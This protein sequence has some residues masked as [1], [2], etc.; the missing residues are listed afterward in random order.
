MPE[1]G[2]DSEGVWD[3]PTE[4]VMEAGGG[5]RPAEG[6][7]DDPTSEGLWDAPTSQ[8]VNVIHQ[9]FSTAITFKVIDLVE[10]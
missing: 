10:L 1:T 3:E 4:G 6:L 8:A 9:G 7:W 2:Q 5:G